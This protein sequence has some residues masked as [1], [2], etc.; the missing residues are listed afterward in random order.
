[1]IGR[2]I[3][4]KLLERGCQVRVLTRGVYVNKDVQIFKAGLSEGDILEKFICG[5]D[6]VFHCAAEL[7]DESKMREV[8]VFGTEKIVNLVR[9][10]KVKYFCHMSSAGVVGSTRQEWV[11][12][13]TPCNPQNTYERTKLEAEIVAS[14]P[15]E[16]CSTVI[17][18]PTNVVD[19]NHLGELSLPANVSFQNRLKAFVKGG[20]CAHIVHAEDVAEA[21]T[22]FA[23]RP[24][25]NLR[26][27]FV[28]LDEDPLNTVASIWLL[29][30]NSVAGCHRSPV[31]RF[32]H[33]PVA[34][35]YLLRRVLRQS[36][37]S[38]SV[39]Y[40][41]KRLILEGFGFT[42]GVKEAVNKIILDRKIGA[43]ASG[44]RSS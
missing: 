3:V 9:K 24:S 26:L 36:G 17:L 7:K 1:M 29:Y 10:H 16:G 25:Q 21:A 12:E 42:L 22:Y 38:G 2:R 13:F 37:N 28:S 8:N 23:S 32:P 40:S 6:M 27:F 15:I 5:A 20:E 19:E 18:R 14:A 41:S 39:R 11:D 30:R 35:P 31:I 44:M 43:L 33:L 4:L 34:I